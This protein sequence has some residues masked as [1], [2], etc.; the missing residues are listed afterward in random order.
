MPKKLKY[1]Y[2]LRT[3]DAELKGY[4]GFQW[5]EKGPVECKDWNPKPVR[6]GGL[7]GMVWGEGVHGYL[8]SDYDARWL[9]L[10][11]V[12]K[13]VV[14]ITEQGGGKWKFPKCS[15]EFVGTRDEALAFLKKK[16]PDDLLDK[17]YGGNN[18]TGI[19]GS[20]SATGDHG[21]ASATGR[22]GTALSFHIAE[23][24]ENGTIII[25]WLDDKSNRFR[26]RV[27]YVGEDGIKPNTKYRLNDKHEFEEV[28]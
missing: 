4:G 5:P 12:S 21:S 16:T 3:C 13:D 24:G 15:V 9:V 7:H 17:I 27:G 28:K 22:E 2:S 20:A 25:K 1:V 11:V 10:K 23:A 26:V 6:G 19:H 14:Y 8:S 18:C